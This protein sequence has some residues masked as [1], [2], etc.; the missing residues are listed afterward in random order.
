MHDMGDEETGITMTLD[1]LDVLPTPCD[2]EEWEHE[3]D[4]DWDD[5]RSNFDTTYDG[6]F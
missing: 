1:S 4:F 5:W 3:Y 6:W 2:D